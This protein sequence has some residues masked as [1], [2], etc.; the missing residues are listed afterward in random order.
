MRRGIT[1][2]RGI[3]NGR[4]ARPMSLSRE[5]GKAG[6]QTEEKGIRRAEGGGGGE[7]RNRALHLGR[8]R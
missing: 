6:R 4:N 1:N 3:P 7:G 2:I 5:D 8:D